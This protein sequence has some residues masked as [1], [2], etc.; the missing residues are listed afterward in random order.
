MDTNMK[1][2]IAERELLYSLKGS[3]ARER[4]V[5]RI[6]APYL[7]DENTVNFKFDPGTAGC[8]IEFDNLPESDIEVHGVDTVQA[9]HFASDLEP[10]LK[11]LEK[12]YDIY[13]SSGEPYFDE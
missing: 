8:R 5:V 4:L 6:S 12:K 10:Y 11:G 2:I 7:V 3:S 9:L 1:K 13:W